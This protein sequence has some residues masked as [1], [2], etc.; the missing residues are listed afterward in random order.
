MNKGMNL[1]LFCIMCGIANNSASKSM[2][3]NSL[4]VG[5][6][7]I[8]SAFVSA[9]EQGMSIPVFINYEGHR[10]NTK[11][12]NANLIIENNKFKLVS[13]EYLYNEDEAKLSNEIIEA[14]D[15][16]KNEY[17]DPNMLIKVERNAVL[18]LDVISFNLDLNITKAAFSLTP[19]SIINKLGPS[20]VENASTVV[21][22]DLGFY[23]N[24]NKNTKNNSNS[25]F[26]LDTLTSFAESH[27][28]INATAYEIGNSNQNVEL[29]RAMLE[30]DYQGYRI[31]L[32]LLS[33]WNLQSVAAMSALS[34]SKVYAISFGNKSSS[35][36]NKSS[37]SLTPVY[38]FLSSPGEVRIYR[39]D[40]LL[41][42]QNFPMG[43]FEIDTTSLPFGIY[44]VTGET[45]IDG[46]VS[47]KKSQTI[48]KTF[49]ALTTNLN[50]IDWEM[51]GGYV[52]F[53]NTRYIREDSDYE[54]GENH[55]RRQLDKTFLVGLS[56]ATTLSILSGLNLQLSNYAFDKHLVME[57][58]ATLGLTKDISLS[59]QSL[60][61]NNGTYRNIISATTALPY[62]IGSA[63]VSKENTVIKSDLP[64]YESNN[65]SYGATINLNQFVDRAGSFTISKNHD[66][67]SKSD[68]VNYEYGNTIYNGKYGNIGLR[69]GVQRYKYE[70]QKNINEKFITLDF[71][72]PLSSWLSAGVSSSNN[73]IKANVFFNKNFEDSVITSAG[74]TVS[75]L[76]SDKDN[77]E[78]NFSTLAYA[79]YDTKYSTGTV[80]INRPDNERINGNYTARGSLAYSDGLIGASGK[81][82]KSGVI[83]NPNIDGNGEMTAQVNG[84]SF[85]VSGKNTFIPLQPY[86]DYKIELMNS[87]KSM[88]SFDIVA[89]RNKSVTLYPGNVAVYTPNVRKLVTVFGRIKS[90]DGKLIANAYIKN[91]IGRTRTDNNGEFSMDVDTRYPVISVVHGN[92]QNVL[93]EAD[94]NLDGSKGALWLG[95]VT[96][97][98]QTTLAQ[99]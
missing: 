95:D 40:K 61:S 52:D 7:I 32:G 36:V 2:Q 62:N 13:I 67:R 9:L 50:R 25:Y 96:C 54:D 77:S 14:L 65:Y 82:G 91:H 72:L 70:N 18:K 93:C 64:I 45:V 92:D 98:N 5:G 35:V 15:K 12:A 88:D 60:L 22:Y 17:F 89:G 99:R 78:A 10:S 76:V 47:S 3:T 84:Q 55:R 21:N 24:I 16:S 58:G 42:I 29:Y 33:T 86:S 56:G 1:L 51:Y 74:G 28:N 6:N 41:S 80:T 53:Q 44:D 87:G 79:S 31:A 27:L 97:E 81:S 75:K 49:G 57:T 11:I 48:N 8:P 73:N 66:K 20:T 39:Q 59:L 34:S 37:S 19:K 68:S 4:K 85:Q 63:W 43:N 46:K 23:N 30:R 69:L 26:N 90:S 71:S 83:I 38:A 94:L